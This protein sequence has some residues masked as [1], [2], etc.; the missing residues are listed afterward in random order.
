[1]AAPI[2]TPIPTP[3]IR[4][5]AP[6]DFATKADAFAASLPQ[7]VTEANTSAAFVDQRAIDADASAQAAA[8][9]EGIATTKAGEASQSAT[10]AQTY[11]ANLESLDELWLGA[12]TSD[13]A[14]GKAGAPLVA[15]NAYVNSATGYLR[16]FNGSEWVQGVSAVS[17]VNSVNGQTGAVD[18]TAQMHA[19]ALL[20]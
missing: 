8:A 11:A 2:I 1:M 20:F 16:A 10:A 9:S 6:A 5:D 4:S 19:T 13:P 7:F 3:P 18:L 15:G 12:A 14:T 17:G